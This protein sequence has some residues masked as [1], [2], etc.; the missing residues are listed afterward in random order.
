MVDTYKSSSFEQ[1]NAET[2]VASMAEGWLGCQMERNAKVVLSS[3]IH[4]EPDLYS[5]D[6]R[7]ICEIFAHIG[8]LKVGQQHKITQDILK[9][10]LLEKTKG[11]Q[12]RKLLL[13]QM[14]K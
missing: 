6:D 3:G 1:Q 11:F 2:Y 8:V 10:L 7:I 5:E 13:L 4:I 9:M 14:I 12:Y